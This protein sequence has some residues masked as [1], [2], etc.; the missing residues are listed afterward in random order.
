M[1]PSLAEAIF[2]AKNINVMRSP[3]HQLAA[4]LSPMQNAPKTVTEKL[5]TSSSAN[6]KGTDDDG[7]GMVKIKFE[8]I[9]R[10]TP[11]PMSI[12]KLI[13]SSQPQPSPPTKPQFQSKSLQQVHFSSEQYVEQ[14]SPKSKPPSSDGKLV[15]FRDAKTES[16]HVEMSARGSTR[17]ESLHAT[18][19]SSSSVKPSSQSSP[20]LRLSAPL[21][22]RGR[23]QV[24]SL[25]N[26]LP[27]SAA[28]TSTSSS[29]SGAGSSVRSERDAVTTPG[30][31][32]AESPFGKANLNANFR[33]SITVNMVRTANEPTQTV[34]GKKIK[35]KSKGRVVMK[36]GK[37]RKYDDQGLEEQDDDLCACC[38]D[39]DVYDDNNIIYCDGCNVAVH[40]QCYGITEV[41]EGSWLCNPCQEQ[42]TTAVCDLCK[43]P[44]GALRNTDLSGKWV[45]VLCASWMGEIKGIGCSGLLTFIPSHNQESLFFN[46]KSTQKQSHLHFQS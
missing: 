15:R 36:T 23:M 46:R 29:N 31:L 8:E 4:A 34:D 41:P 22:K 42:S 2:R 27:P 10:A 35:S 13:P 14:S 28:K 24:S 40:Q 6:T 45:H 39:G 37:S 17:N 9:Y 3:A 33:D 18:G 25:V 16:G 11:I 5:Q 21:M 19:P 26:L 1:E 7:A 32:H 30:S 12:R 38:L 43:Q 44:G 20:A